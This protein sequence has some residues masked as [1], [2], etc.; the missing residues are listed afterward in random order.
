MKKITIDGREMGSE[1]GSSG[2]Q[3]SFT[4]VAG[5]GQG[6]KQVRE[7]STCRDFINDRIIVDYNNRRASSDFH[8][9]RV[10]KRYLR[11]LISASG[12]SK[13]FA[14]KRVI[15]MY[16]NLAG[17]KRK[18]TIKWVEHNSKSIGGCWMLTGPSKWMKSSHLVSMVTLI[19]RIVLDCGGFENLTTLDEVEAR[20]SSICVDKVKGR[21]RDSYNILPS[22]WPMFRMLMT[23][24]DA[25]F[26]NLKH[27]DANPPNMVNKWHGPGGI[28]S[29]CTF[30]T[31]VKILDSR[32]KKEAGNRKK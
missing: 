3:I 11:L 15:N 20:F 16:E 27:T 13:I 30:K 26:G 17:W 2:G 31:N 28:M 10:D 7:F 32:M 12:K 23:R 29:L 21:Y 22:S 19:F 9:G 14:A 6:W 25:I 8:R 5:P 4:L 18:S 1:Y 24:Y